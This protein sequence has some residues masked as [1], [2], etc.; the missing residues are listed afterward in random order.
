MNK[1]KY[2]AVMACGTILLASSCKPDPK[3]PPVTT[4]EGVV[5]DFHAMFNGQ[6]MEFSK[7][8]YNKPDGEVMSI[9][10]WGMIL[11]HLSLVKEDSSLVTLGDGYQYIGFTIGKTNYTYETAPAGKYIGIKFQ[12]GPDQ[13]INH[14]DPD[15]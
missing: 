9:S 14:S 11:A 10:N 13:M 5:L 1:I 4:E 15:A 6:E 2:A 3:K 12:L 7:L 8:Q